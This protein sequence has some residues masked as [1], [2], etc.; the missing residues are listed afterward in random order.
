MRVALLSLMEP[1]AGEPQGLRGYLPIGGRS[2]ARHQLGLALAFGVT[3]VV[4]LADNLTGELVAL[5]HMAEN[6]GARFHVIAMQ[7]AL[8]PLVSPEDELLVFADGL[9]A[10]PDDALGLLADGP[11][12]ITLPVET[13]LPLGFERIDLNNAHAGAMRLPGRLVASLGELPSEW[14]PVSALLRIAVQ[15]K[16][17]LR[18]LPAALLDEGRWRL[19]RDEGEALRA[20][21]AWLRL[22]TA[23]AHVRSPGEWIAAFGMQRL[24]PAFLHAGTR[25]WV[26]ALA[27]LVNVL[28]ALGAGWFGWRTPGFV[29]LGIAW[30]MLVSAGLLARIERDSLLSRG[31]RVPAEKVALLGLDGAF[32]ALAAWRSEIPSIVG[33]PP[34]LAWFAPL[35]LLM[36]LHL[37]P[38]VLPD[39]RWN[40]WL[41]DRFVAGMVLALTSMALPFDSAI[42]LFVL[43]LLGFGLF[44]IRGRALAPN[45]ELT[46]EG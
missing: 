25:P 15:A 39:R 6:A 32:L 40:W 7:R 26:L 11:A 35:V 31:S 45:R 43:G 33:V 1:A 23:S 41:R 22:H 24:G 38:D 9:L 2:V 5:Q 42:R 10:M 14:N 19:L 13:G 18:P 3:R 20:E 34:A 36:L 46:T 21:P 37:L 29:L 27:A 30:L 28:L 44:T 4:V 16:V 8:V 12:V 17:P